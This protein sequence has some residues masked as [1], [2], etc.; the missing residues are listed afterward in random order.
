MSAKT[1]A[2]LEKLIENGLGADGNGK[3][4]L[5]AIAMS[6]GHSGQNARGETVADSLSSIASSL[7]R[8]ATAL[9]NRE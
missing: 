6:L 1:D 9:E 3:T 8:I 4:F 7:Q 5:E 2:L